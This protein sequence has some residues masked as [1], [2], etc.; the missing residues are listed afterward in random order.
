MAVELA[1]QAVVFW[2]V[3]N[4]DST[5]VK[6]SDGVFFQIDLNNLVDAQGD[7]DPR[8]PVLDELCD[9]LPEGND[10]RPYLAAFAVTH[11]DQDHCRGF[12]ELLE[13]VTIG[14]LWI[15]PRAFRDY[16]AREGGLSADANA[17]VR[18]ARRRVAECERQGLATQAGD[19]VRVI[20]SDELLQEDLYS[21][22][23][24]EFLTTP[25][26]ELTAVGGQELS[27]SFRAFIHAPFKEDAAGDERNETS[28]AMQ[29]T[30]TAVDCE[31]RFMLL[32][33]LGAATL[34]KII[35]RSEY[36]DNADKLEWD[37]LL[38][39][40]HG[41][42]HAMYECVNGHHTLDE[43]VLDGL[44]AYARPGATVVMSCREFN[45]TDAGPPHQD[46]RNHYEDIVGAERVITTCEHAPNP[47]V[48]SVGGGSCGYTTAVE[49]TSSA[50]RWGA[51]AI[52]LTGRDSDVPTD[53]HEYGLC[54]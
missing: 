36:N 12:T 53:S 44:E 22:L 29:V 13:R 8:S 4:G 25:R 52:G 21:G 34:R 3:G 23:P 32:G 15:T 26:N 10:G 5:T 51:V 33:D 6:L 42:H 30:L 27:G 14:E 43:D 11:P 24:R 31:L 41:S 2:S 48:F 7:D 37:V 35:E 28:L 19:L 45:T 49:T 39:P 16:E 40:H 17:L 46:A 1:E 50:E 9:L 18:E 47:V 20:G 54:G 38:A